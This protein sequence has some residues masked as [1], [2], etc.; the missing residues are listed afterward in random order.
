MIPS[1]SLVASTPS[2]S[3]ATPS[4]TLFE[5]SFT[6]AMSEH[7]LSLLCRTLDLSTN[8]R[9]DLRPGQDNLGFARLDHDSGLFLK[10][11]AT[12]GQWLLS[13]VTWGRPASGTV[14]G[15]NVLASG[16]AHQI[17]ADVTFP[18]RLPVVARTIADRYVVERS[19]TR[20][21]RWRRRLV[22]MN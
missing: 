9:S 16:A 4:Q 2:R 11:S 18:D 19:N 13:A 12:E 21:G 15:W 1:S 22:G 17:D 10:R 7:D 20:W 3:P 5:V 14:H 8:P 6:S